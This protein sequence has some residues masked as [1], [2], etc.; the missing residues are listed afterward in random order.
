VLQ[1]DGRR[2]EVE[3]PDDGDEQGAELVARWHAFILE[4]M[5]MKDK[6]N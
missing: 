2:G 4:P 1:R 5:T 3:S 6:Q